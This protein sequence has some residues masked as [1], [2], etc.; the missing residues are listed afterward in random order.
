MDLESLKKAI[1]ELKPEERRKLALHILELEKDHFQK[2]VGSQLSEDLE[3][4]ARAVQDAA[5]KVKKSL[6]DA[7]K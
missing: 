2:N 5:E 4:F 3:G 1:E 6:K 7:L